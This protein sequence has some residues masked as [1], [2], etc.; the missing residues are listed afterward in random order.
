MFCQ[1]GQCAFTLAS[2]SHLIYNPCYCL[3]EIRALHLTPVLHANSSAFTAFTDG[4]PPAGFRPDTLDTLSLLLSETLSVD[5][6]VR[7]R[8]WDALLS[9]TKRWVSIKYCISSYSFF[10]SVARWRMTIESAMEMKCDVESVIEV[11][12]FLKHWFIKCVKFEFVCVRLF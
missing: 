8:Q 4:E 2:C 9:C 3:E 10:N 11:C 1:G 5:C 12:A 7:Q 6:S